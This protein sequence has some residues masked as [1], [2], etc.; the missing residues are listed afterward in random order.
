M[1]KGKPYKYEINILYENE[2]SGL[3]YC[4]DVSREG[5][6]LLLVYDDADAAKDCEI[7]SLRNVARFRIREV[8]E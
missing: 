5:D 1:Q 7:F 4:N 3:L 6:Y 8:E 2:T